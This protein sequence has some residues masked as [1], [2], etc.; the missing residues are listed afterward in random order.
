MNNILLIKSAI[1]GIHK[2]LFEDPNIR[3][4][5]TLKSTIDNMIDNCPKEIARNR[6][7]FTVNSSFYH[8]NYTATLKISKRITELKNNL[9]KLILYNEKEFG[10][11]FDQFRLLHIDK[12]KFDNTTLIKIN[13]IIE[14]MDIVYL[15][16]L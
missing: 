5:L 6:K 8:R 11:L 7:E 2:E 12:Y 4:M 10:H 16:L 1:G 14:V 13:K 9:K 15:S 3:N